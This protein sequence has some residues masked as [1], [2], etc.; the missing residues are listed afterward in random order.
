[1]IYSL[2]RGLE[3]YDVPTVDKIV[4]RLDRGSG[5]FSELLMGIVESV[6]FQQRRTN[7]KSTSP[8]AAPASTV[9]STSVTR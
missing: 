6:P 2:G 5:R 4:D 9:T 8:S 7:E 1:M 3:Y